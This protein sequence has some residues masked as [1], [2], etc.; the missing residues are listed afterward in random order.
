MMAPKYCHSASHAPRGRQSR[1]LGRQSR[2]R[3]SRALGRQSRAQGRQS[4]ARGCQSRAPGP[5]VTHPGSTSP[6]PTTTAASPPPTTEKTASMTTSTVIATTPLCLSNHYE[7]CQILSRRETPYV[8]N[9]LT[10]AF[11]WPYYSL[12]LALCR[13]II[14]LYCPIGAVEHPGF[15]RILNFKPL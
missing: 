4:L 7:R 12:I 8:I 3:Q 15:L 6:P 11:V 1:A 10:V 14:N 13:S 5:P 9:S 2:G